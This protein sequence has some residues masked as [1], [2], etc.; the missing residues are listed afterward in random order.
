[1]LDVA[2]IPFFARL[3]AAA[4]AEVRRL[5][6][7][8]EFAPHAPICRKGEAGKS[9]YAIASG[10]VHV[11]LA[12]NGRESRVFLGPGEVFGEMSLLADIPVSATVISAVETKVFV[13]SKQAFL[14]LLETQPAIHQVL[15]EMLIQRLRHRNSEAGTSLRPICCYFVDAVLNPELRQRRLQPRLLAGLFQAV[16]YYSPGSHLVH[17]NGPAGSTTAGAEAAALKAAAADGQTESRPQGNDAAGAPLAGDSAPPPFMTAEAP[18][19][20]NGATTNLLD[21]ISTV[22]GGP[23]LEH[24]VTAWKNFGSG[25][26][27]LLLV[28][29]PQDF[30][31]LQQFLQ[32][33]DAVVV[34]TDADGADICRDI[35]EQTL[36]RAEFAVIEAGDGIA[37]RRQCALPWRFRVPDGELADELHRPHN[38]SDRPHIDWLARWITRREVGLSLSAGAA[39]GFAHLGVM[40]VLEEEGIPIDCV[41]GTSMGGIVAL[42]YSVTGNARD[43][44]DLVGRALGSNRGVRDRS[45]FPRASVMAGRKVRRAAIETFG[46]LEITDLKRPCAVIASDLVRGERVVMDRGPVA[47][48]ALATSSI[49]G[50]FPPVETGNR[51]LVDGALVSRLPVDIL[52]LRRCA[53]RIAV[54]VIPSPEARRNNAPQ[55][56]SW[57]RRRFARFFGFRFV[58]STAWELLGWYHGSSQAQG[59]DILIEPDTELYSGY[60]FDRF[61]EMVEAGRRATLEKLDLIRAA[62]SMALRPGS[63]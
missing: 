32:V 49:P 27:A 2:D 29:R 37:A 15:L 63:P 48:A 57:L 6:E 51:I 60:D 53:L 38:R 28:I 11:L 8:R 54:N 16:E 31:H 55:T 44:T 59:A 3:P 13:V 50:I 30:A 4:L 10:G 18:A 41:T 1:M 61:H 43:A 19:T 52:D 7:L 5:I 12:G 45:W 24:L 9:F 42:A 33:G 36:D 40:Q 25:D 14:H 34:H 20:G 62:A 26:Q 39:R 58:M 35:R 17:A 47:T 21:R 22:E 56:V 46:D 23:W